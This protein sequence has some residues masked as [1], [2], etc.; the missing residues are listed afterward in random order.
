MLLQ[1]E[2]NGYLRMLSLRLKPGKQSI[3]IT[4]TD[5]SEQII[6][7]FPLTRVFNALRKRSESCFCIQKHLSQVGVEK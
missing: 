4:E 2:S 3:T 6:V 5:S 1:T 7:A